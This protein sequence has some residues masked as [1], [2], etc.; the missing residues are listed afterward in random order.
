MSVNKECPFD[1]VP[2]HG[3]NLKPNEAHSTCAEAT[4]KGVYQRWKDVTRAQTKTSVAYAN[5]HLAHMDVPLVEFMDLPLVEF[6]D[7]PLVEFM[8]LV[9]T[10]M[11]GR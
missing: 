2:N 8:Y 11:P 9:F 3:R 1:G 6:L 4:H 10:R 7:V 5:S